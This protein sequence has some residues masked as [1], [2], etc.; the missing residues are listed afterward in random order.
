MGSKQLR[1][2]GGSKSSKRSQTKDNGDSLPSFGGSVVDDSSLRLLCDP[3]VTK[4]SPFPFPLPLDPVTST[5]E[6]MEIGQPWPI[7]SVEGSEG[8]IKQLY[9][10]YGGRDV[11]PCNKHSRFAAWVRYFEN[12]EGTLV[13]HAAFVVYWLSR[14]VLTESPFDHIKAYLFPLAIL[15]AYGESFTMGIIIWMLFTFPKWRDTILCRG[16]SFEL[17][18]T[19]SLG[20]GMCSSSRNIR[21]FRHSCSQ[22]LSTKS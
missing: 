20:V 14:Y 19:A 7:L 22:A 9:T 10:S 1:F 21:S 6:K 2:K 4:T 3:W 18:I 15:L 17:G 5:E 8:I 11:P 16:D 13:C 12:F